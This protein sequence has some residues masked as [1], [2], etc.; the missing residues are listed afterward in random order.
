MSGL[1]SALGSVR[2]R[3]GM[4]FSS[5]A[6]SHHGPEM[7][8]ARALARWGRRIEILNKFDP[9][10][11]SGNVFAGM[12]RHVLN[13]GRLRT[14]PRGRE[15]WWFVKIDF[16]E[17]FFGR[18]VPDAPFVL[19]TH[20]GDR[21][22]DATCLGFLSHPR[23]VVWFSSNV[24]IGHPKLVPVPVG[25][26]NAIWPH[27]DTAV[28]DRVVAE[29]RTKSELVEVSF[30]LGSNPAERAAC[31]EKTGL[32]ARARLPFPRY[33]ERLA[34][35]YFC[36][37]PAGNGLDCHRTWEA[38]YVRTIP[39][40][41]SSILTAELPSLP[42]IVLDDWSEYESLELSP[43]LYREIWAGWDPASLT[44]HFYRRQMLDKAR[45]R[46]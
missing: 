34:A 1:T 23:L 20:N 24:A 31:L 3:T 33:L 35:S 6:P 8:Q 36:L 16:L 39:I 19:V 32:S 17:H 30:S 15:G 11:L 12:C 29:G 26:A 44:G 41:T 25:V 40:V 9:R 13:Y 22:V 37:S 45:R 28:F 27:G 14:N 43:Q 7:Q 38:F 5:F 46:S 4:V 21:P 2:T 18:L 10:Y 42:W